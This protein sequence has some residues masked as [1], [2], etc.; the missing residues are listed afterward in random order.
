MRFPHFHFTSKENRLVGFA[1]ET[2]D[3]PAQAEKPDATLKDKEQQ[4][5][6]PELAEEKSIQQVGIALD[7][8][9]DATN[10]LNNM[11][12]KISTL[13]VAMGTGGDVSALDLATGNTAQ[14]EN[15]LTNKPTRLSGNLGL[16]SVGKAF[17]TEFKK[18][19]EGNPD[20]PNSATQESVKTD[21]EVAKLA[22]GF[23]GLGMS[24]ENAQTLAAGLRAISELIKELK[25][26]FKDPEADKKEKG[27]SDKKEKSNQ[28]FSSGQKKN[29]ERQNTSAESSEKPVSKIQNPKKEAED[30]GDV[31]SREEDLEGQIKAEG[32]KFDGDTTTEE[33]ADILKKIDDLSTKLS[34]VEQQRERKSALLEEQDRR[35]TFIDDASKSI[36][37]DSPISSME[38]G[39]DGDDLVLGVKG[40]DLD[41]MANAIRDF[42]ATVDMTTNA[43]GIVLNDMPPALFAEQGMSNFQDLLTRLF[44]PSEKN[45][46]E[47][48]GSSKETTEKKEKISPAL[49]RK[50]RILTGLANALN[51]QIPSL[52]EGATM[53]QRIAVRTQDI[54]SRLELNSSKEDVVYLN[55]AGDLIE[56]EDGG[57]DNTVVTGFKDMLRSNPEA[58]VNALADASSILF[59]RVTN[60]IIANAQN[61]RGAGGLAAS[62]EQ[63]EP[64]VSDTTSEAPETPATPLPKT[65]IRPT[66][67]SAP[68][69]APEDLAEPE[70]PT[71]E[72]GPVAA[73][74]PESTSAPETVD[75]QAKT[76][77]LITD[78][79]NEVINTSGGTAVAQRKLAEL[80]K[81]VDASNQTS[82]EEYTTFLQNAG[83]E[84]ESLY[85]EGTT[86]ELSYN[87][88]EGFTLEEK[89]S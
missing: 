12:G 6:T 72:D 27:K 44:S 25:K 46:E 17:G 43:K 58:A 42:D 18:P 57:Y 68:P 33:R 75:R 53:E 26:M 40:V 66:Q 49:A 32:E 31:E 15:Q 13:D 29:A 10:H 9:N 89:N 54:I 20:A 67:E 8:Q 3:Q 80:N 88:Q 30:I 63:D 39:G 56:S 85:M 84:I 37:P 51:V 7:S 2:P 1:G 45:T 87:D 82:N 79:V 48:E 78:L 36:G 23:E 65:P 60:S 59:G 71:K 50:N 4:P 21:P 64:K 35:E 83:Q 5:I 47:D 55:G 52:E 61:F 11:Q 22:R 14:M 69:A 76:Q 28:S 77:E 70:V 73:Q 81:Y 86:Y 38:L 16:S 41:K 24:P 34:R 62:V 19:G 74:K